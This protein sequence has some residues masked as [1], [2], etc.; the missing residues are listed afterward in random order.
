MAALH[1]TSD[2][3]RPLA[4]DAVDVLIAR[5]KS[6]WRAQTGETAEQI[7]SKVSNFEL[8]AAQPAESL[9]FNVRPTPEGS[10]GSSNIFEVGG[11]RPRCGLSVSALKR[12]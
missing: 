1:K 9:S 3:S 6:T 11:H 10:E 5:V 4:N 8:R 7:F 12:V 2:T